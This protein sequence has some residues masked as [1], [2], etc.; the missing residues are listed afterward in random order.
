[1]FDVGDKVV[2]PH[3][4]AGTVVSKELRTVLGESREYLTIQ[5]L[6]N[7]LT[8]NVPNENAENVGLRRVIDEDAVERVI[9]VLLG[10]GTAMPKNWHQ[11]FKYNRDKIKTGDVDR[12]GT[13]QAQPDAPRGRRRTR[14][15]FLASPLPA[16]PRS[17]SR[18]ARAPRGLPA[19]T[20]WPPRPARRGCL[21]P[22]T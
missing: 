13:E 3:H 18:S 11:R 2:Y 17:P 16:R 15:A 8:V 22:R 1:M 9:G 12:G 5:I 4:G 6:H 21:S 20:S 10:S 14:S 7:D 19:R